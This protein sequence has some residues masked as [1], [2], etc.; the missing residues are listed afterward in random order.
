MKHFRA[1]TRRHGE[2]RP[3]VLL[4]D[5]NV[6]I[7]ERVSRLLAANFDVVAAVTNGQKA[8]KACLL[9]D[10]DVVV[11]DVSMPELDGFQVA[12]ALKRA[13]SRAT[14]VMLSMHESDDYV[15]VA[16]ESGA[17]GKGAVRAIRTGSGPAFLWGKTLRGENRT[18]GKGPHP[19]RRT[20][21]SREQIPSIPEGSEASR[22]AL[23][24]PAPA[25]A[26][27]LF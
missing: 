27:I 3:T 9:L 5:D 13:A 23:P 24:A 14:I 25:P 22:C 10:P 21:G 1:P 18:M 20:E 8:L 17:R 11:L 15:G 19:R 12:R 26:R 16:I 6:L 7:L 2:R 4:A